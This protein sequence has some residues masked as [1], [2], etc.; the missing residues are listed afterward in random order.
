MEKL[1]FI[2]G[3]ISSVILSSSLLIFL[4]S[5]INLSYS[6]VFLIFFALMFYSHSFASQAKLF[7]G[8]HPFYPIQYFVV[9]GVIFNT[10]FMSGMILTA[11]GF[12]ARTWWGFILVEFALLVMFFGNYA[13][14]KEE[15]K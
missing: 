15:K 10:A 8:L 7:H 3:T 13:V 12:N 11:V 2:V 4:Y 1:D 9:N 6:L 14:I 5:G